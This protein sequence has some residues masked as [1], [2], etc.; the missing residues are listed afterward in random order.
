MAVVAFVDAW[1][2]DLANLRRTLTIETGAALRGRPASERGPDRAA[3]AEVLDEF[4]R[5]DSASSQEVLTQ[6]PIRDSILT[7]ARSPLLLGFLGLGLLMMVVV[8]NTDP[9]APQGRLNSVLGTIAGSL[10]TLAVVG[11]GLFVRKTSHT[12]HR[13]AAKESVAFA[14]AFADIVTGREA[15]LANRRGRVGQVLEDAATWLKEMVGLRR[16]P[17]PDLFALVIVLDNLDRL[18]SPDAL[19]AAA[20]IRALVEIPGSRCVFLVPVDRRSL[21]RHLAGAFANVA[22]E[23]SAGD[24][25]AKFFN[26]DLTLTEPEPVDLRDWALQQ[27]D[28][29]LPELDSDIRAS[30]AQVIASAAGSSPRNIRR[31]VNGVSSRYRL[32]DPTLHERVTPT[33]LAFVEGLLIGFPDLLPGLVNEPRVLEARAKVGP[34]YD[35]GRSPDG[36][37]HAAAG[38]TTGGF[39]W[40]PRS[41][42][43][44]AGMTPCL[45]MLYHSASHC[46]CAQTDFGNACRNLSH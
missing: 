26:L 4:I 42:R 44:Y 28:R 9:T 36:I 41:C 13:A 14:E 35:G 7:L 1:T 31:I 2:T 27:V 24:Y 6:V 40:E 33:Q 21:A 39:C 17:P 12:T 23:G 18:S 15:E 29:A 16:D 45:W 34:E 37:V 20:Q 32:L 46:H 30:V 11:S 25:L 3:I 5:D 43:F 22:D 38:R 10:R 19:D 8:L